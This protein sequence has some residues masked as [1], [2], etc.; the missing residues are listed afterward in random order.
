MQLGEQSITTRCFTSSIAP[1]SPS[2]DPKDEKSLPV[3]LLIWKLK[4]AAENIHKTW[5]ANRDDK[6]LLIVRPG[7]VFGPGEREMSLD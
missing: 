6:Q 4:T 5:Q 2:E 7:V 1:Y 3:Q